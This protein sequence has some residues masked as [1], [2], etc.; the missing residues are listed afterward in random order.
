MGLFLL[1]IGL[2]LLGQ[3]TH[4]LGKIIKYKKQ[5]GD[6]FSFNAYWKDNELSLLLNFILIVTFSIIFK[7]SGLTY[8]LGEQPTPTAKFAELTYY[9]A[10]GYFI[11]SFARNI[12]KQRMQEHGVDI[13]DEDKP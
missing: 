3:I 5:Y 2:M 9:W 1:V 4:N 10:A 6:K 7:I 11:D 12:L 13:E 8:I